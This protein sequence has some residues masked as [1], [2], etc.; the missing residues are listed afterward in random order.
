M[1]RTFAS[2]PDA[3]GQRDHAAAR[4]DAIDLRAGCAR[5]NSARK[6]PSPSPD[7]QHPARCLDFA[8]ERDP[9]LLELSPKNEPLERA[10]KRRDP[11][12]A[13][14]K[15]NGSASKG[16]RRTRSARAVR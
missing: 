6:R 12:E 2:P 11:I 7:D 5:T 3:A 4:L 16:V 9:R 1:K 14:R 10:I 8:E 13:H 15:E